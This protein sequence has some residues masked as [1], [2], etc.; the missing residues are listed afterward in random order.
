MVAPQPFFRPR[1]TPFS[2]LHRIRA[3]TEAGHRVDLVTYP[4]GETI[5]L[6]GLRVFRSARP[7][8]VR[9]VKIGPSFAKLALDWPLYRETVRALKRERYDVLHT[10]EEAAFFGVRLARRFK[11]LHIYDMHSSLPQ[12]LSNFRAFDLR[13]LRSMFA[14]LERRVLTTCDGVITICPDLADTA[15]REC[16]DTPHAMIENTGDD[17]RIF[18]ADG[19]DLRAVLGLQ[20]KRL[21][22]YTGTLET[23]QGIDLL[24]DGFAQVP[25]A[26]L[27]IVGGREQQIERYRAQA[28][29]LGIEDRTTFLGQVHPS[30][31]PPAICAA[32]VIVSP[33]SLGTNTPLKVYAYM[34]SGKPIVAT[35]MPTHTQVMNH[36]VAMLVPPTAEG[37]AKGMKQVLDDPA[38]AERLAQNAATL[39]DAQYS[40]AG[41][42]AK[43]TDLYDRT[44]QRAGK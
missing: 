42:A 41:Y 1:G 33:R 8:F 3:L 28:I 25:D 12:Q 30:R 31:I 7:P 34:R 29:G 21:V 17:A 38:L 27:L 4:F 40:D 23:Y 5:P 2:V 16:G 36:D 6:H 22:V 18:P 11:L 35:D 39:A 10:H 44:L 24:L 20:G 26:H 19:E 37:L 13:P 14:A 32:D 9:D 15:L 43:V